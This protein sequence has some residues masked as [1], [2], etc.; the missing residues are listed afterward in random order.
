MGVE[1]SALRRMVNVKELDEWDMVADDIIVDG[2]KIASKRN[3]DGL[4]KEQ[5]ER[6]QNLAHEGKIP[7]AITIKYGIFFIPVFLLAFLL[8]L[9]LF[10]LWDGNVLKFLVSLLLI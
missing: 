10:S 6:I 1:K 5:I 8:F 3:V 9:W 4:T 7:E 2:E